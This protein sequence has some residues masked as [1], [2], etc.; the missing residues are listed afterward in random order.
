[1][2]KIWGASVRTACS[3]SSSFDELCGEAAPEPHCYWCN[4]NTVH[5]SSVT[6]LCHIYPAFIQTQ[7]FCWAPP[8]GVVK[9]CS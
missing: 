6:Y 8:A 9:R 5:W 4:K 3:P 7:F 2:H 1:M